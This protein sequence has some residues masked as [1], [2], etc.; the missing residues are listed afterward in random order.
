MRTLTSAIDGCEDKDI[1]CFKEQEPCH[2]GLELPTQQIKL[3]IE[4]KDNFFV[5]DNNEIADPAPGKMVVDEDREGDSDIAI[6]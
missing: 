5:P 6:G 1:H 2:A 4:P 3:A